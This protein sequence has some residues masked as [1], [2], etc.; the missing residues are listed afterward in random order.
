MLE[1]IREGTEEN[2]ILPLYKLLHILFSASLKENRDTAQMSRNSRQLLQLTE[3]TK[4]VG[5][6][7]G[8][9]KNMNDVG[10]KHK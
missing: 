1:F 7:T 6:I 8:G 9:Y 4:L 10:M 2:C 3:G 5:G